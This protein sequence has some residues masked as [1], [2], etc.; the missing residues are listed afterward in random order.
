M[1][2]ARSLGLLLIFAL[3]L[4]SSVQAQFPHPRLDSIYPSGGKQGGEIEVR[5]KGAALEEIDKLVF[6]HAGIT[7]APKLEPSDEVY[8]K[9]LKVEN[10]FVVKVA[11]N[12]PVGVHELRVIGRN[13]LS[14]PIAFA[15]SALDEILEAG[16][17]NELEKASELSVGTLVNGKVDTGARDYWKVT[18]KANQR[19]LFDCCAQRVDSK[20]DGALI[21][22]NSAGNEIARSRNVVGLD[23]LLD[24]TAPVEGEYTVA[25]YDFLFGGGDGYH[26]RLSVHQRPHI[27]FIFPPSGV[28]GNGSYTVYGRNLPGGKPQS[29]VNLEGATLESATVTVSIPAQTTGEVA[30][31][32]LPH[33][34]G[35]FD[36]VAY[37]MKSSA[38]ESNA[39]PISRALAPVTV[40]QADNDSA[41]K[42]QELKV[43]CE[44]V[45]Q[46]YPQRDRDWLQFSAKAGEVF[47]IELFSHRLGLDADPTML[48]QQVTKDDKGVEVVKDVAEIDDPANRATAISSSFDTSTDDPSYRLEVKEDGVYRLMIRDQFGDSRR[49]PRYVYRLAITKEP[50]GFALVASPSG[51]RAANGNALA[52]DAASLRAGGECAVD[53]HVIRYGGYEGEIEIT[54][55]GLPAG[56][57]S[58]VTMV[59]PRQATAPLLIWAEEGAAPWSGRIKISGKAEVDGKPVTRQA[60][61]G[62]LIVGTTNKTQVSPILRITQDLM[63]AVTNAEKKP[64][65]IALGDDQVYETA[66][67]GKFEIP[68][69][70]TRHGSYKG[71]LKLTAVDVVAE[72]KPGDVNIAANATD[73]KLAMSL[74]NNKLKEGVYTFYVRADVK[75]KHPGNPES[76][77][78]VQE[79]QKRLD[80]VVKKFTEE[81]KQKKDD[82]QVKLMLKKAQDAKKKIDADVKTITNTSKAK[83]INYWAL[84]TPV[85][86]R[87]ARS[88]LVEPANVSGA[89]KAGEKV[90]V[91]V[92]IERRY[93]YEDAVEV[94]LDKSIANVTA[95]KLTIPKGQTEGKLIVTATDKATVGT[96]D[97]KLQLQ[98]KWNNITTTIP[99]ELK[100]TITAAAAK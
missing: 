72:M 65:T 3:L 12:A 92:K 83:D 90:E 46:F 55:E 5:I 57:K 27:D 18:L 37:R 93:G 39:F 34:C 4:T 29:G 77:K 21:L 82:E 95:A 61:T 30:G 47:N 38:G 48:I 10:T 89:V 7:A 63:L 19:V 2:D 35:L 54:A 69:K 56:V 1:R 28:T 60:Q 67:G 68:V 50:V 41:E 81:A 15:V 33:A 96:H 53:V 100:L 31:R 58:R 11:A 91:A 85:R 17:N 40:E 97:A 88:P 42:A 51:R 14:N 78:R 16:G 43:P 59:G 99:A 20:M 76:L 24:F 13:G 66:L 45:G 62:S 87:V 84:S 6:S 25:V 22:Y 9:G 79:E 36:S 64:L 23:P 70:V 94:T 75:V 73:G 8:P 98:T 74:T 71:A 86:I 26:Y 52:P 49:D 44:L 80:A 32:R